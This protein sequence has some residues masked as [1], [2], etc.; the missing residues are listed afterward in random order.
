VTH[1]LKAVNKVGDSADGKAVVEAMK[2]TPTSDP[3]YGEGAI[4]IDGRK[5]HPM[6]LLE[7]KKPGDSKG[8]WDYFRIVGTVKADDAFRPLSEGKCPLVK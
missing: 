7:T 3:L 5:V 4:R 1:Y 6:H 2:S 8:A